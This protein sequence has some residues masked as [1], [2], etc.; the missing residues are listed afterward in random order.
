MITISFGS[1]II[2]FS[3]TLLGLCWALLIVDD[4][5]TIF[6]EWLIY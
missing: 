6:Q 5:G 3:I 2:P 4:E 1:W